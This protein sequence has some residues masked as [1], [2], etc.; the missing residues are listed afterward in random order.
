[1]KL[2]FKVLFIII[3]TS[4]SNSILAQTDL[5]VLNKKE[6]KEVIYSVQNAIIAN[7]VDLDLGKKMSESLNTKNYYSIKNP[8]EFAQKLTNDLQFISKDKHLKLNFEPERIAQNKIKTSLE[9][10]LIAIQKQVK[11][12]KRSNFGFLEQKILEGNIGYLDLRYFAD[13][14][15]AKETIEASMAFLANT[16][17]IIIDLRQ[18]GGGVPSSLKLLSSYFFNE[19]PVLLNTFY[20]RS[21]DETEE[22]LTEKNIKG[23][24]LPKTSLYILTSRNTFSAAEAFAYNLKHLDRAIIVGEITRGGANRTKR[25]DI[26]TNFTVS[27]PYIKAIHPITKS[28]WEGI[29]VIPNIEIASEDAFV[30]AYIEAINKTMGNHP[31]KNK[32]LNKAGYDFLQDNNILKA[33]SIFKVNTELYKTDANAWDSLGEAYL[34]NGEEENALKSYKKALALDPTSKSAKEMIQKLENLH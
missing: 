5:L 1:M 6:V 9:D 21:T 13:V 25:I 34:K 8:N 32:I 2:S 28:N 19:K 22:F 24:R 18:N 29:G 26:D 14:E 4:L 30:K 3:I 23:K 12:M 15:Y 27:M 33:I 31:M 7:Y 10:S 11:N 16:N 17:A 20:N